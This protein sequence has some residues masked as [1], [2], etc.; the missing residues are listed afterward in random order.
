MEK[1]AEQAVVESQLGAAAEIEEEE[2]EE[3]VVVAVV[4]EVQQWQWHA[5][6]GITVVGPWRR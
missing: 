6:G 2:E 4:V 1:Q 5:C 3:G